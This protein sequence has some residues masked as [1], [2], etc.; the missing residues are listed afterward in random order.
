VTGP[1][2]AR[3]SNKI[4]RPVYLTAAQRV[5]ALAFRSKMA[6]MLARDVTIIDH[7]LLYGCGLAILL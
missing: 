7:C 5:P 4:I 2:L 1:A 3:L 6:H